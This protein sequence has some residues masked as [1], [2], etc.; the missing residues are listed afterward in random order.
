MDL[1]WWFRLQVIDAKKNSILNAEED[2][3][4]KM[5]AIIARKLVTGIKIYY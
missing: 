5:F 3:K 4:K 2:L 1:V